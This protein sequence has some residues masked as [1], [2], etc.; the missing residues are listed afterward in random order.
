ML[1]GCAPSSHVK[2]VSKLDP[3]QKIAFGHVDIFIDGELQ[4]CGALVEGSGPC[5]FMIL[6]RNSSQAISFAPDS[7]SSFFLPLY[8]GDYTFLAYRFQRGTSYEVGYIDAAFSVPDDSDAVYI[9]NLSINIQQNHSLSNIYDKHTEMSSSYMTRFQGSKSEISVSLMKLPEKTGNYTKVINICEEIWDVGCTDN[10]RGI[11]PLTPPTEIG[12]FLQ[13]D[14]LSPVMRWE[15]VKNPDVSYDLI[16]Y[17]T[18]GYSITAKEDQLK[19]RIIL[20]EENITQP[21]FSIRNPLKA[22]T[23]YLWSVRLRNGNMVSDWSSYG[24]HRF[25]VIYVSSSA[26]QWFGFST[27]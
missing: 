6:P 27:P 2:D 19:G 26:G 1:T 11:K 8:P 4:N 9:G 24:H 12:H 10:Y 25:Y 3:G 14:T 16:I 23:K 17:E 13:T 18:V 22:N 5:F 7:D 20:Y 15:G 21:E